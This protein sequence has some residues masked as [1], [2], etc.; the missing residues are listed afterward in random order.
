MEPRQKPGSEKDILVES[1]GRFLRLL[2]TS[3]RQEVQ[4]EV[5]LGNTRAD[6]LVTLAAP[7]GAEATLLVEA[8]TNLGARDVA[9]VLNQIS[10][11]AAAL[12]GPAQP[13]VC[14]RYLSPP[15]RE[16]LEN[17]GVSYA[18]AT[19]NVW[20]RLDRPALF[21]RDV[22][23]QRDPW[24]GPGRPRGSLRGETAARLVRALVDFSPPYSLPVLAERSGASVAATYRMIDFLEGE[25]LVERE[26]RGSD[27]KGPIAVV[28][29]RRLLERWGE[30]ALA[31]S[32]PFRRFL[33]PRG[34]DALRAGLAQLPPS[35]EYVVTGS[36]AAGYFAPYAPSMLAMLYARDPVSLA[37]GLGLRE[38][39][40]G[41]NVWIGVP[42]TEA[43]WDRGRLIDG[44]RIAAPSQIVVD[45]MNSP[46]RGPAEAQALLDW[47]ESDERTWRR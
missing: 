29:W 27:R 37:A 10:T 47:M 28:A 15:V 31:K 26:T 32:P 36:L 42:L 38:V 22:G 4:F 44:V 5:R 9:R 39:D 1:L 35:A 16:D 12:P 20:V 19:G 8:K 45:L 3:W 11:A 33:A 40:Q 18:D 34:L 2:P 23:A 30:D 21:I 43:V 41:A 25:G 7:E 46:G 17:L 6:A 14:A 24:R 13:F